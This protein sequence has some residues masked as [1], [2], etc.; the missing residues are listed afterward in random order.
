MTIK[1]SIKSSSIVAVTALCAVLGTGCSTTSDALQKLRLVNAIPEA[2]TE[3]A[4]ERHVEQCLAMYEL[5]DQQQLLAAKADVQA[6]F[7]Y[8]VRNTE[9]WYVV[10]AHHYDA[11]IARINRDYYSDPK[12]AQTFN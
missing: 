7:T 5:R 9:G 12:T 4:R 3:D 6:A 1:K 10:D 8:C 11:E 2:N